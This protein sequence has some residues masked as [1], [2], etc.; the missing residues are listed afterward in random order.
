MLKKFEK[1]LIKVIFA[2]LKKG[3]IPNFGSPETKC[4]K[5]MFFETACFPTPDV[6][7]CLGGW[8]GGD[9]R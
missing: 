9:D 5:C 3:N 7:G 4:N 8:K 1:V 6:V 2:E